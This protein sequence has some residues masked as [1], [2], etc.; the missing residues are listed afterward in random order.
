MEPSGKEKT[1]GDKHVLTEESG[2]FVLVLT[3]RSVEKKDKS[4][5]INRQQNLNQLKEPERENSEASEGI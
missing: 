5:K 4:E 3:S 2:I 1:S